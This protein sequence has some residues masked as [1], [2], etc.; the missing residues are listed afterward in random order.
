MTIWRV[1]VVC[2]PALPYTNCGVPLRIEKAKRSPL[3]RSGVGKS[4][5]SILARSG[6]GNR[7]FVH[8]ICFSVLTAKCQVTTTLPLFAPTMQCIAATLGL[9]W[10]LAALLGPWNKT[11][12]WLQLKS[13]E[14]LTWF[15]LA[16][17]LTSDR[18]GT[19]IAEVN[20]SLGH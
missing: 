7:R 3:A 2:F 15:I 1:L 11:P 18:P 20:N 12:D 6:V 9:L 8:I 17:K 16:G 5:F 14:I 10:V 19:S 13:G 4:K